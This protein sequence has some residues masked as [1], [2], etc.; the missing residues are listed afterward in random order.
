MVSTKT[1]VLLTQSL[2]ISMVGAER[3]KIAGALSGD[4]PAERLQQI[5]MDKDNLIC[6]GKEVRNILTGDPSVGGQR[7]GNWELALEIAKKYLEEAAEKIK[8]FTD[9]IDKYKSQLGAAQEASE[10]NQVSE[11]SVKDRI[12]FTIAKPNT[13]ISLQVAQ[14]T[15]CGKDKAK[16]MTT[17]LLRKNMKLTRQAK[18][19]GVDASTLEGW[20]PPLEKQ[21][22]WKAIDEWDID[23]DALLGDKVK[24]E[25]KTVTSVCNS[26]FGIKKDTSNADLTKTY[27]DEM[28]TSFGSNKKIIDRVGYVGKDTDAINKKIKEE[29]IKL[30][31]WMDEKAECERAQ[32]ALID[33]QAVYKKLDADIQTGVENEMKARDAYNEALE[34]MIALEGE[35]EDAVDAVKAAEGVLDQAGAKHASLKKQYEELKKD[36]SETKLALATLMQT[37][38]EANELIDNAMNALTS[39]QK[40]KLL[41]G[42]TVKS[43]WN[44]FDQGVLQPLDKLGLQK[45]MPLDD[46]FEEEFGE[47]SEYEDLLDSMKELHGHCADTATKAFARVKKEEL[48]STL[49]EMCQ[50]DAPDVASPQFGETVVAIGQKMKGHMETA[51]SWHNP[52]FGREKELT[53]KK[54]SELSEAQ[55]IP[56]LREIE[57]AFGTAPYYAE[58]LN[59]WKADDPQGFMA[60]LAQLE[61]TLADLQAMAAKLK[62]QV[63]ANTAKIRDLKAKQK[64]VYPLLMTAIKEQQ[65]AEE[66]LNAARDQ[67][68][69]LSAELDRAQVDLD[70]LKA[71][72]DAAQEAW[73]LA[74][75]TFDEQYKFATAMIEK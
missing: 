20:T 10:V 11:D 65:V 45:G 1:W 21:A 41:V 47:V 16:Y 72:L 25:P 67:E 4:T 53:K 66:E 46:Y 5:F 49:M 71:A 13:L 51:Q 9:N 57:N 52:F 73:D 36:D 35:Q 15:G 44:Y 62:E 69:A 30:K 34:A 14:D 38:D 2:S 31:M 7:V 37:F 59:K 64:E 56:M 54:L 74:V 32:A 68:E 19:D 50:F 22:Y 3:M 18:K 8:E 24:L 75:A 70:A 43:M 6:G 26:I 29:G 23:I 63:E 17:D 39:F 27:C 12:L 42:G 33:F 55:E 28:C 48:K 40:L 58:Y 61:K 60:L